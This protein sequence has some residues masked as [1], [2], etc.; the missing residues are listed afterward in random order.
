MAKALKPSELLKLR[1]KPN[2]QHGVAT[3]VPENNTIQL[4]VYPDS[5]CYE[6]DLDRA[7][8][9]VEILD[10]ILHLHSKTWC[11]PQVMDD[12]LDCLKD[13]ILIRHGIDL[14]TFLIRNS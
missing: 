2:A 12:F 7:R 4:A 1:A 8:N 5:N 3:Y 6:V 13:A 11:S 10:W 14:R 9:S